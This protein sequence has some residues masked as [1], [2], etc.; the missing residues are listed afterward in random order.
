MTIFN[1]VRTLNV[2]GDVLSV[3][4]RYFCV[5]DNTF[6]GGLLMRRFFSQFLNPL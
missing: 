2:L 5:Y 1:E 6:G 3:C 4:M